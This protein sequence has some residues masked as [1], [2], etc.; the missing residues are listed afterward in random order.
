[1]TQIG[2][3]GDAKTENAF[4]ELL[5]VLFEMKEHPKGND[6]PDTVA[7]VQLVQKRSLSLS[8]V[9]RKSMEDTWQGP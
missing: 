9:L 2:F 1:M 8:Q 4:N 5:E 6:S 7:R 3:F